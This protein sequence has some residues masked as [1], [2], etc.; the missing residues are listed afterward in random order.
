[1]F[2]EWFFCSRTLF[3]T[4]A[5]PANLMHVVN[6]LLAEPPCVKVRLERVDFEFYL[7]S[8]AGLQRGEQFPGGED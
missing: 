1:M 5:L 8:S 7:G 6:T 3:V 4:K 2:E